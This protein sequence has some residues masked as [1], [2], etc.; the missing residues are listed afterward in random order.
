MNVL[1]HEKNFTSDAEKREIIDR[2]TF[3]DIFAISVI[4]LYTFSAL[5]ISS[6]SAILWFTGNTDNGS[7]VGFIFQK[8][9]WPMIA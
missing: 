3:G 2:K 4:S 8:I 1:S 7:P 6:W 9:I 5:I